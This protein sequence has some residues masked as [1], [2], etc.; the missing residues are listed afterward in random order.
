MITSK[1]RFQKGPHQSD[2]LKIVDSAAFIAAIESAALD[3]TA[4]LP[5]PNSADVA[6]ANGYR[7]DGI[8]RALNAL[9][10]LPIQIEPRRPAPTD[11]LQRH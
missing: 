8:K 2:F 6:L 11:N 9:A 7:L 3:A 1:D 4:N 10:N 5:V